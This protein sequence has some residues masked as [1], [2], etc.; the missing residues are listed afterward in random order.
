VWGVGTHTAINCWRM[1]F[2]DR[3]GCEFGRLWAITQKIDAFSLLG[4]LGGQHHDPDESERDANKTKIVHK[5]SLF[6][7]TATISTALSYMLNLS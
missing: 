5:S 2:H 7:S 6:E 4:A 3:A 1:R